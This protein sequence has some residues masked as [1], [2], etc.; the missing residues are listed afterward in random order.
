MNTK[1]TFNLPATLNLRKHTRHMDLTFF[2]ELCAPDLQSA[3]LQGDVEVSFLHQHE[4]SFGSRRPFLVKDASGEYVM[5]AYSHPKAPE[6]ERVALQTLNGFGAPKPRHIGNRFILEER[7]FQTPSIMDVFLNDQEEAMR[8]GATYRAEIAARGVVF[9]KDANW[10]N[11]LVY[12]DAVW[13]CMD[14]GHAQ[15][16]FAEGEDHAIDTL[17]KQWKS[18]KMATYEATFKEAPFLRLTNAKRIDREAHKDAFEALMSLK[19][20]PLTQANVYRGICET[21]YSVREVLFAQHPEQG[22]AAVTRME[23]LSPL[24]ITQF[25]TR[26]NALSK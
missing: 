21:L 14:F 7:L 2:Q 10:M 25:V 22:N 3:G 11:D 8:A 26:Y 16:F 6:S 20:D 17:L 12:N 9:N 15:P 18:G 23:T 19:G 5:K 1:I 13:K 24:F 4:Y